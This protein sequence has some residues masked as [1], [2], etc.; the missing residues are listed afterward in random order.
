MCQLATC[1]DSKGLRIASTIPK[2]GTDLALRAILRDAGLDPDK[3]VTI[4]FVGIGGLMPALRTGKSDAVI[5]P[6]D[7]AAQAI[8]QDKVARALVDPRRG[9]G[10]AFVRDM[11]F[12]S[13][14]ASDA[15]LRSK[16]DAVGK[17]VRAVVRAQ[18]QLRDDGALAL[19]IALRLFPD[20]DRA[21]MQAI[22]DADR[23][24]YRPEITEKAM[25]QVH[26]G[27]RGV[28]LPADDPPIPFTDVVAVQYRSLWGE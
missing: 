12:T 16:P 5:M 14:Q 2:A 21:V 22:L 27:L 19:R 26:A 24:S 1:R 6:A 11:N 8:H 3:D 15:V 23:P 17:V 18:K 4:E 25:R 10:P 13:L 28:L 20:V 7:F 9:D